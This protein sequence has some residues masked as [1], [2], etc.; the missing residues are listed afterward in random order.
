MKDVEAVHMKDLLSDYIVITN[1]TMLQ[2]AIVFYEYLLAR[3][4]I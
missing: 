1:M 4:Y 3:K 2:R